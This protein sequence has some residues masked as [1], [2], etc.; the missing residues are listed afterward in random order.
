[1]GGST[2]V[3]HAFAGPTK[4]LQ[5]PGVPCQD[6]YGSRTPTEHDRDHPAQDE[7]PD[8]TLDVLAQ[9]IERQ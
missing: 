2:P 9:G 1:M 4:K 6:P 8:Q 7:H 3:V 5:R